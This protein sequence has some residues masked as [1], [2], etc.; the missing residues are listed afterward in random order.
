MKRLALV[1][2]LYALACGLILTTCAGAA[3][4]SVDIGGGLGGGTPGGTNG[5]LQYNNNGSLGGYTAAQA[6]S[7]LGLGTAATHAAGDFDASG[8]AAAMATAYNP[9]FYLGLTRGTTVPNLSFAASPHYN[10]TGGAV[11]TAGAMTITGAG[12]FV[13]KSFT[14]V[15]G[16]MYQVD[17]VPSAVTAETFTF[18]MGGVSVGPIT[19]T[20]TQNYRFY[21]LAASTAAPTVTTSAGTSITFSS[22]SISPVLNPALVLD[23][24]TGLTVQNNVYL[25]AA[26]AGTVFQSYETAAYAV[27]L[28][29]TNSNNA[30]MGPTSYTSNITLGAARQTFVSLGCFSAGTWDLLG[31]N[32]SATGN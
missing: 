25:P 19:P 22:M 9:P 3:D 28:N 16:T 24:N 12:T 15:A 32:G 2:A 8:A 14:P 27:V 20:A 11:E 30:Y 17:L 10:V 13:P 23:A 29:L 1:I 6:I 7:F 18:T 21:I 26:L 5:Q 31:Q 4:M